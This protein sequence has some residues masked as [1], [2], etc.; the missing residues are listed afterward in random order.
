MVTK[1]LVR[2]GFEY[3]VYIM[4]DLNFKHKIVVCYKGFDQHLAL[5]FSNNLAEGI[6]EAIKTLHKEYPFEQL[7]FKYD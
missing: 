7:V 1:E 4:D 5:S 3:E 6:D 2:D